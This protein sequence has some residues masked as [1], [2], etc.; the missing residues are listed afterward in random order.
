[1]SCLHYQVKEAHCQFQNPRTNPF[2]NLF[3]L[4]YAGITLPMY[5]YSLPVS[6]NISSSHHQTFICEN[7]ISF[8]IV[9]HVI[10]FR[11]TAKQQLKVLKKVNDMCLICSN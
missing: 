11:I 8:L 10:F 4:K 2:K 9:I 1:M 3:H 5:K 7:S 6:V